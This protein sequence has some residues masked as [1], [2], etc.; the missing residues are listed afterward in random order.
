MKKILL[1]LF[2]FTAI[3]FSQELKKVA[4]GINFPEGP[5]WDGK[6]SLYVSGCFGGYIVKI[7][8]EEKTVFIDSGSTI[9]KQTNGLTFGKDGWLYGCD[10][11]AGAIIKISPDKEVEVV[12]SG[13]QGKSFDVPNDL[14]FHINGD[15]YFS[16][17]N[18]DQPDGRLFRMHMETGELQMLLDSLHYPNGLVF[19]EDGMTLYLS[20]SAKN[21]VLKLQL[22]KEGNLISHNVFLD[23]PGG[24]PDGLALDIE[25]NLYVAHFDGGMVYVVS[26]DAE[27]TETI[28]LPGIQVSNVEFGGDDL[29]TLYITEDETGSVYSIRRD[30]AG[31]KLL[32]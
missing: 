7:T 16:E 26:P 2:I 17:P 12:S 13:Y 8:G 27:I 6:G 18:S 32:R 29:K 20:E 1:L 15:L 5:A 10:F 31:L 11:G 24:E 3:S 25:G 14:A 19:T 4:D 30:T 28:K 22:D 9:L 21:R 23:L